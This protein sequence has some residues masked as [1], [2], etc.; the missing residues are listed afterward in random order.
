[1]PS[2]ET[3]R[4]YPVPSAASKDPISYCQSKCRDSTTINSLFFDIVQNQTCRCIDQTPLGGNWRK[5]SWFRKARIIFRPVFGA[6]AL[7]DD[8]LGGVAP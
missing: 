8:Q 1:M 4:T 3:P 6:D 5:K 7:Q 2:S